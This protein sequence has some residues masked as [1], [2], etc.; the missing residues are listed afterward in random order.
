[1][2]AE[3]TSV[4]GDAGTCR[5]Q[6]HTTVVCMSPTQQSYPKAYDG[7]CESKKD[8]WDFD[9]LRAVRTGRARKSI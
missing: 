4:F 5:F 9:T 8:S 3:K 2:C 6:K 1:M 7:F